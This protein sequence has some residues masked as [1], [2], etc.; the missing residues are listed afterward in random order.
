MADIRESS[1]MR[2]ATRFADVGWHDHP[3]SG[4]DDHPHADVLLDILLSMNITFE[5]SCSSRHLCPWPLE[6]P[7][8]PTILLIATLYSPRLER[9]DDAP[10]I[11][12][13]LCR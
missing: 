13:G 3:D 11:A 7:A 9:F 2:K 12:S 1:L 8:F 10:D 4:D 6:I 5:S